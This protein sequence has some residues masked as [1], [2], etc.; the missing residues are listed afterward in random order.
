VKACAV[1]LAGLAGNSYMYLKMSL[2]EI[3]PVIFGSTEGLIDHLRSLADH[4]NCTRCGVAMRQRPRN[5]GFSWWCPQ[6]K[7]RKSIRDRSFFT[8][9]RMTLQKWVLLMHCWVRNYHL[10]DAAE[11]SQIDAGTAVDIFQWFRD[12]CTTKL[13]QTPIILGGQGIVV[14]IDES[15]FR[16]KPKVFFIYAHIHRI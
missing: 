14:E 7:T 15:L 16:H 11:E 9:S 6:C 13:L 2:L 4:C 12:V 3:G 5:D 10:R 1:S 8:K